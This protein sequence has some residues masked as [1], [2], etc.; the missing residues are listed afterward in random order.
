MSRYGILM[1][2][3]AGSAGAGLVAEKKSKELRERFPVFLIR[4]AVLE[5]HRSYKEPVLELLSDWED[6]FGIIGLEPVSEGGV[7]KG[8]WNLG[9]SCD[10]GFEVKLKEIPIKQETVEICNFFDINPYQLYSEGVLLIL[11][12]NADGLADRLRG[13]NIPATVI[14]RT[15]P[16]KK[17]VIVNDEEERFLEP[18]KGDSMA[19]IKEN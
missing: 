11:A 16:E 15:H 7:F 8:L 10:M 1:A 6:E 14:G 13:N 9:E 18:R 5:G 17:R 3:Y 2:G 19:E 4:N 12:A